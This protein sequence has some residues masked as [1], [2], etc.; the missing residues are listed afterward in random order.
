[1][2]GL[3]ET[4]L[5]RVLVAIALLLAFARGVGELARRVGQ[6]EVLG[7]LLGGFLLGPSV[8]GA[9]LPP[10]YDGLF[11]VPSVGFVLS[12]ISWVGAIL[13][14]LLAGLEVDLGIIRHIVRPG[15]LAGAFAIVA[16]LIGGTVFGL[17]VLGQKFQSSLFLGIVLS[18]TA[19]SVLSKILSEREV[20]RRSYAQTAL[21]AGV[22]SEVVVWLLIAVGSSVR[23][24][25]ALR[26]GVQATV[27][28]VG[29]V[30]LMLRFGRRLTFW[31]MRRVSDLARISDARLTLVLTLTFAVAAVTN[32]LGLHPLLGAFVFG[33]LLAEAPRADVPLR[34]RIETPVVS[35]FGPIFFALA[36][37]RVDLFQLNSSGD[38][39]TIL[40]LF[41]GAAL[42]KIGFGA[43]GARLG[44][45]H[46]W[47]PLI[48][49]VGLNLKGGTDVIVA[50]LGTELGLFPAS[51]YTLYAVAALLTVVVSPPAI[52]WL[53]RRVPPSEEEAQRLEHEEAARRGYLPAIERVLVPALPQ[54]R[55]LLA[56]RTL[57]AI[58]GTKQQ[59]GELFDI[60]RLELNNGNSQPDAALE[61]A[62][63][64]LD[65]VAKLP[66]VE[67]TSRAAAENG[68]TLQTILDASKDYGMLAIGARRPKSGQLLTFGR[69]QDRI[70]DCAE[71]DVLL[72]VAPDHDLI[73]GA[74]RIL[75]PVNG[76]EYSL[77]AG[78]IAG[79]LA[80]AL[81]AEVVL[82]TA[83]Q[84]KLA[85][86]VRDARQRRKLR[87]SGETIVDELRFRLSRL[88][89][90]L[91]EARIVVHEDAGEAI[92]EE[93][94]RGD[95]GLTVFGTVDRSNDSQVYLGSPIQTVLLRSSV[96]A[97]ILVTH[98]SS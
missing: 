91:A 41:A 40:L 97:V 38:A 89:V 87:R 11:R 82:F 6:P 35:F 18:V 90:R 86:G 47:E 67:V 70:V 74:K 75:V 77:N 28:A 95:Y 54:L 64:T 4:D 56:V 2:T 51:T 49:G 92:L 33:A 72:V 48:I 93:L 22:A 78:D 44:G 13:L 5:L 84:A 71:P 96:P 16:S 65:A 94:E 61:T 10:V 8:L 60:T 27:L 29:F 76:F 17:L 73:L 19:V 83:V 66:E 81:D 63:T 55:P 79:Y 37:T 45:L 98:E 39:G 23:L 9:L 26:S 52:A 88:D 30:V 24:D 1:M 80:R 7:Q 15:L 20:F 59:L 58:A 62:D 69:L 34:A 46:G 21:A 50:I 42:L 14:L 57:E 3:G 68:S 43:L 12:G 53:E 31:A 32:A 85:E 25:Q 36:G